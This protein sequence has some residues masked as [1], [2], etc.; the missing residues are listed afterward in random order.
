MLQKAAERL[1]DMA[2]AMSRKIFMFAVHMYD[3]MYYAKKFPC[4]LDFYPCIRSEV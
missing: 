3:A 4:T 2:N 1:T